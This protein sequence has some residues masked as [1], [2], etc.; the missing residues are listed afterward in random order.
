[1]GGLQLGQGFE[2]APVQPQLSCCARNTIYKLHVQLVML[3]SAVVL[4]SAARLAAIGC[5]REHTIL[6]YSARRAAVGNGR[7]LQ[8]FGHGETMS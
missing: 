5:Q 3:A 1:M 7:T 8:S 4:K 2:C 6:G